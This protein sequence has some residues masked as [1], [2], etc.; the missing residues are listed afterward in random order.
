MMRRPP[1]FTLTNTI[2][3]YTTLFRSDAS[4]NRLQGI[5]VHVA[6]AIG[7]RQRGSGD[8]AGDAGHAELGADLPMRA[9][10][11]QRTQQQYLG[12]RR[13]AQRL[14]L[15]LSLRSC[16]DSILER[17]RGVGQQGIGE[18]QWWRSEEHTSELQSLM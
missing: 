2:F 14:A 5:G 9:D 13:Q 6:G 12:N 8:G 11:I 4:A 1:R 18:L 7:R 15:D 16:R 3:P 17:H 10:R